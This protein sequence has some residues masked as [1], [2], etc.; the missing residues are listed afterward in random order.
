MAAELGASPKQVALTWLL[1]RS[2]NILVI[3]GTSSPAHLRE[4]FA[5][6]DLVLSPAQ[7]TALDGIGDGE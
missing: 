2:P 5:A 1:Q 3:A 7:V 6:A 4:N